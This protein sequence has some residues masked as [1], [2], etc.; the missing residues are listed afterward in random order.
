MK[1]KICVIAAALV[2]VLVMAI[3]LVA[4]NKYKWNVGGGDAS[5]EVISN[6]GYAVQQGKYLYYINGFDGTD[7]ADNTFGVP[8]KQ[9]IA[10]TEVKVENGKIVPDLSTTKVVVP[11][12]VLYSSSPKE[13]GFAIYGEWIYYATPNYDRDKNGVASTTDT[14]IMRTKIDGSVTQLIAQIHVRT[15]QFFFTEHRVIYLDGTTLNYVDFSGMKTDKEIRNGKGA[16]SGVLAENVANTKALWKYGHDRIYYVRTV[17]GSDSYKNYNEICSVNI[18]G[19]EPTVIATQNTF[20]EGNETPE[21]K[22][23][24]V[25]QYTLVGLHVDDGG[26]AT[27]YYTK[28]HRSGESSV[29]DGF[30][31]AKAADIN[32]TQKQLCTSTVSNIYPLGY[33]DGVFATV[34]SNLYLLKAGAN[35]EDNK[36]ANGSQLVCYVDTANKV[37][38]YT[39]TSSATALNMISYADNSGNNA[40]VV[41]EGIKVDWLPLDFVGSNL[42]FFAT[43]DSNEAHIAD[44]FSFD[45]DETDEDGEKVKTPYLGFERKDE[46]EDK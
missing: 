13:G 9:S 7:G 14:D 39:A 45:K 27:L 34:N 20:L 12:T 36:I 22:I 28:T 46:D 3:G 17:T 16:V 43:D 18:D 1:K 2:L 42:V 32:G 41:E 33:E 25:F 30:F 23:L 37:V 24:K 6:G 40:V 10:R 29:S 15:A 19:G 35:F 5:A 21:D 8:V 4:C 26:N 11:K 38:Y 44:I 31:C